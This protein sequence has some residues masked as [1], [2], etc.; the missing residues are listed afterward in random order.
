[1][2]IL[3]ESAGAIGVDPPAST[4]PVPGTQG[5]HMEESSLSA[6]HE[7]PL[8]A[9]GVAEFDLYVLRHTCVAV[10]LL[11]FTQHAG[12]FGRAPGFAGAP[13]STPGRS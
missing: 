12:S 5:G 9:S 7:K 3:A 1:M 2:R 4:G 13:L 10:A 11:Y 6:D 8:A